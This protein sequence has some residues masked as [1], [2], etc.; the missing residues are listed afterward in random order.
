MRQSKTAHTATAVEIEQV[1]VD[2][3]LGVLYSRANVLMIRIG[4]GISTSYRTC[5]PYTV[6]HAKTADKPR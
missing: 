3:A 4:S 1:S 6:P 5:A 2:K